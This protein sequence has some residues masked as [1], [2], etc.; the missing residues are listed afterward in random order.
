MMKQGRL[1]ISLAFLNLV[2]RSSKNFSFCLYQDFSI[3]KTTC[4]IQLLLYS[5]Q[6]WQHDEL[7]ENR[8]LKFILQTPTTIYCLLHRK[9]NFDAWFWHKMNSFIKNESIQHEID[10]KRVISLMLFFPNYRKL[11]T[12]VASRLE[13]PSFPLR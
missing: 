2:L 7:V 5:L 4:S 10:S 12:T 3:A 13:C 9:L 11:S 8:R 6:I 1:V